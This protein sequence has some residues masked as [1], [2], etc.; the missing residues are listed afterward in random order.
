DSPSPAASPVA[1]ASAGWPALP[2]VDTSTDWFAGQREPLPPA[3]LRRPLASRAALV[4]AA[5]RQP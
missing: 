4:D 3:L 5:G 1:G 2:E